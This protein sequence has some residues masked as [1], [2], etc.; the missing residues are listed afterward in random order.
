MRE[1]Q[2]IIT[3]LSALSKDIQTKTANLKKLN[4]DQSKA[5][6]DLE[7]ARE[8]AGKLKTEMAEY[9]ELLVPASVQNRVRQ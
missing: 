4:E 7:K 9:M 6:N 1:L 3:D 8:N 5:F 2:E